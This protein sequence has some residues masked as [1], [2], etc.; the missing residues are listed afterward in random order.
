VRVAI[1]LSVHQLRQADLA[2][3]LLTTLCRHGL[4]PSQLLPEVTDSAAMEDA[5][6]HL[7]GFEQFAQFGTVLSIVDF[8]T[9]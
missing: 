7:V 8:R 5:G 6:S 9:G 2:S 4:E 1:N 3:H